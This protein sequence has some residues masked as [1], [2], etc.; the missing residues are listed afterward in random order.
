MP[1]AVL[2]SNDLNRPSVPLFRRPSD[3]AQPR[4]YITL[5]VTR[6]PS[7][8]CERATAVRSHR[9]PAY[10]DPTAA[11]AARHDPPSPSSSSPH[12]AGSCSRPARATA[13]PIHPSSS[14]PSHLTAQP[15][16]PSNRS[17]DP[18][19]DALALISPS[20]TAHWRRCQRGPPQ[21][22]L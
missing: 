8:P 1:P 12:A 21:T 11:N 19:A 4:A 20:P 2:P 14:R 18:T 6:Q 22:S 17:S 7:H 15:Q 10:L 9:R 16:S 3:A 13:P 5:V